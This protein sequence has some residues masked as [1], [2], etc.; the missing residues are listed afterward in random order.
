[1]EVVGERPAQLADVV[2]G[3]VDEARLAPPQEVETD[4]VE[5]GGV[6]DDP[7]VVFDLPFAVENV[8]VEPG[9]VGAVAGSPEHC[10]DAGAPQVEGE[11]R[12]V[13]DDGAREALHGTD[14]VLDSVLVDPLIDHVE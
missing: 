10:C 4:A 2:A 12:I 7:A 8:D 9:V 1:M 6:V 13:V 3:A 5:A 11:Q 14:F